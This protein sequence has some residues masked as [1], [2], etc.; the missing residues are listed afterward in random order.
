LE[1][2][3]LI[4]QK[5]PLSFVKLL[6]RN[7]N[8]SLEAHKGSIPLCGSNEIKLRK[9]NVMIPET[10][11]EVRNYLGAIPR[12]N[13]GGCGVAALAMYK[14]LAKE[15]EIDH[16]F[17][18]VLCYDHETD[19]YI[20]N[21]GVLR[22]G[23]GQAVACRHIGIYYDGKYLDCN[24]EIMLSHYDTIQFVRLEDTWFIQSALNNIVSWN[25]LF[26]RKRWLSQI[27]RDLGISLMEIKK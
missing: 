12:I 25:N 15:N 18:F 20:N 24:N 6:Q 27:E 8:H 11:E 4:N 7:K 17:K 10:F 9:M 3:H 2:S 14:W 26:E 13:Q 5:K 1:Y 19:A 22:N 21:I 16:H 23:E